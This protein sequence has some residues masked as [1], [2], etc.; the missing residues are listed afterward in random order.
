MRALKSCFLAMALLVAMVAP[1]AVMA[2]A[3]PPALQMRLGSLDSLMETFFLLAE[4]VGRKDEAK[5]L[6]QVLKAGTGPDGIQGLDPKRPLGLYGSIGPNGVDSE[7]VL[8]VPSLDD[9]KMLAAISQLVG[10]L[11]GKVEKGKGGGAHVLNLDQSPFPIYFRFAK[12]YCWATLR[13]ESIISP[14]KLPDPETF[15]KAEPGSLVSLK[16]DLAGVPENLR[17]MAVDQLKEKM[18][19]ARDQGPPDETPKQKELRLK[20]AS[21]IEEG[22][23]SFLKEGGTLGVDIGHD[24]KGDELF[25]GFQLVPK[26]GG[27]LSK[28]WNSLTEYETIGGG[29]AKSGGTLSLSLNMKIPDSIRKPLGE[30]LDEVRTQALEKEKDPAKKE[31][32]KSMFDAISPTLLAGKLDFGMTL[33][34]SKGDEFQTMI[35]GLRV[36]EGAKVETLIRKLVA[37]P[38]KPDGD[39]VTLDVGMSNGIA[40]HKVEQ[41]SGGDQGAKDLLGNGPG[42]FAVRPN[43]ILV[44]AGPD[45]FAKLKDAVGAKTGPSPLFSC[46]LSFAQFAKVNDKNLPKAKIQEAVKKSFGKDP[47]SDRVK[48]TVE[49]KDG[50]R[51]NIRLKTPVLTFFSEMDPNKD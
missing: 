33:S 13:D 3:K 45:G 14:A 2:Q 10:A 19:E 34:P 51:A 11:G 49:S 31:L 42:F 16:F 28:V 43:A 29:L 27:E 22:L 44:G 15:L 21:S 7:A 17:Q 9:D 24:K 32:A 41:G 12:K 36:E 48:I 39:K 26:K 18:S 5:Q 46:E 20:I 4:R 30:A 8:A 25:A 1:G 50:I 38:T 6:E 47:E 37:V 35:L 23:V 40:L